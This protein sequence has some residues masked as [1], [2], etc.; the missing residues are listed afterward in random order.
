MNHFRYT[1]VEHLLTGL[2]VTYS[3]GEDQYLDFVEQ[4]GIRVV[5]QGQNETVFPDAAGY[6]VPGGFQ[7]TAALQLVSNDK[8]YFKCAYTRLH[9]LLMQIQT[10]S[11]SSNG[12]V[13]ASS[14]NDV[15]T[16]YYSNASYTTEVCVLFYS[17]TILFTYYP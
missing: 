13:C 12:K 8:Y 3:I 5:V 16:F 15:T 11:M 6:S 10:S 14:A 17:F 1:K 2:T 4:A 7:S 9:V